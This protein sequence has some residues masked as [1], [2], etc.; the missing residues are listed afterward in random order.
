[1]ICEMR[2]GDVRAESSRQM[3]FVGAP[4]DQTPEDNQR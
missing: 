4:S 3:S 2:A 1:V